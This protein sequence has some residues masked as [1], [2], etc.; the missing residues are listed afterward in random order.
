MNTKLLI[1]YAT[2]IDTDEMKRQ[3]QAKADDLIKK[4]SPH[5]QPDRAELDN[6]LNGIR[7]MGSQ[8]HFI[9]GETEKTRAARSLLNAIGKHDAAVVPTTLPAMLAA[10]A[11]IGGLTGAISDDRGNALHGAARGAATGAGLL[12]GAKAGLDF[13]SKNY[14]GHELAGALTGAAV[15]GLGSNLLA[16][17]LLG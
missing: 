10:G 15:G 9:T 14:K 11:G 12:G 17:A 7:G 4:I 3:A 16:K 13:A 6:I 1:K 5:E 8:I 2:T